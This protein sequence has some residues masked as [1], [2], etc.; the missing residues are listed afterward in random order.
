AQ[1][2]CGSANADYAVHGES[3]DCTYACA[4]DAEQSCG[5]FDAANVYLYPVEST[6]S[7]TVRD[8]AGPYIPLGCYEDDPEDRIMDN[9]A[10]SDA[11]MT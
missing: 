2:W 6:A 8:W 3:S 5:G 9:L 1:C 4:G 11:F 10:L 7:P